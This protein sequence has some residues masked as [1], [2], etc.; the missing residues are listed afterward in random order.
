MHVVV[1]FITMYHV[2]IYI[3]SVSLSFQ[4]LGGPSQ[5]DNGPVTE[6]TGGDG[7]RGKKTAEAVGNGEKVI[8]L[9]KTYPKKFNKKTSVSSNDLL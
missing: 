9:K 1:S 7:P 3:Y 6:E 2:Y 4:I 5:C 8:F